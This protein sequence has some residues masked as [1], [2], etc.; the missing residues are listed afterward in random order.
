MRRHFPQSVCAPSFSVR[1]ASRETEVYNLYPVSAC[2]NERNTFHMLTSICD[3]FGKISKPLQDT[4]HAS[5]FSLPRVSQISVVDHVH[6]HHL[7]SLSDA[8]CP[9]SSLPHT[10]LLLGV[11]ALGLPVALAFPT[12]LLQPRGGATCP[13]TSPLSCPV[14]SGADSC[15]TNT[16]GGQLVL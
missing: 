6:V 16:P 14:P 11:A 10:M 13:S 2:S 8:R 15:C 7:D 12:S 3:W 9:S 5:A 4:F 1:A